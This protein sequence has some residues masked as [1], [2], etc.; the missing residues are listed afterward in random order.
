MVSLTSG[1]Y[2]WRYTAPIQTSADRALR[3]AAFN[4]GFRF[5]STNGG[6]F[7]EG[8]LVY[9]LRVGAAS[10]VICKDGSAIVGEWGRDATMS[11]NV[12][13]VRQNLNLLVDHGRA[14]PSLNPDDIWTSGPNLGEAS[15]T[16]GAQGRGKQP[17]APAFTLPGLCPV[18]GPRLA[19]RPG[20]GGPS[21]GARHQSLLD[22][23]GQLPTVVSDRH[24][25]ASER[26]GPV[27]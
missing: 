14:V 20:W 26:Q 7:A 24:G 12:V 19:A 25:F 27:A 22:R 9:P 23:L 18:V 6:Y 3:V 10:L 17:M 1:G 15:P 8:R 4:G 16:F 11:P 5:P 21:A 2:G 13:A